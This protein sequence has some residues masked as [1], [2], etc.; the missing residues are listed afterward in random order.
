[1]AVASGSWPE[2]SL[3][4]CNRLNR[5]RYF[6]DHKVFLERVKKERRN[7]FMKKWKAVTTLAI[8]AAITL[9][10]CAG[11][12]E[13]EQSQESGV[14]SEAAGNGPKRRWERTFY[15]PYIGNRR[16]ECLLQT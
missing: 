13:K 15:L 3:M 6:R 14:Q 11:E 1:M 16:Q 2:E 7:K 8:F 9:T 5:K 4:A 10:A 12:K